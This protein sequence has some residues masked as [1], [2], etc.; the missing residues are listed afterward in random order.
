MLINRNV[1]KITNSRAKLI[2]HRST[3]GAWAYWLPGPLRAL[4]SMS[5][6]T[7]DCDASKLN[8][9]RL[10]SQKEGKLSKRQLMSLSRRP[11]PSST[12]SWYTS[13]SKHPVCLKV[14]MHRRLLCKLRVGEIVR[15]CRCP[16]GF[17]PPLI[18]T[19]RSKSASG[20]GPP[21]QKA[22]E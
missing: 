8:T 14:R 7:L 1:R 18:W 20:Y 16:S 11:L 4:D 2:L 6:D 21:S 17:G 5:T 13:L 22:S 19:P 15:M 12:H 10:L 9:G 3:A